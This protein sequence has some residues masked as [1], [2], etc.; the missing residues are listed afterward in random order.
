MLETAIATAIIQ[1]TTQCAYKTFPIFRSAPIQGVR[2]FKGCTYLRG[3]PIQGVRLFKG[4]TYSRGAPIQGVRL[5]KGCT[6]SRGARIQGV[7]LFKGCTYSRERA[8]HK[9]HRQE[10]SSKLYRNREYIREQLEKSAKNWNKRAKKTRCQHHQDPVLNL[11]CHHQNQEAFA[12][13]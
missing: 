7:R 12:V 9:F 4:C 10:S 2:L 3:A 6:Y 1:V 5:F 8:H 13:C 11:S